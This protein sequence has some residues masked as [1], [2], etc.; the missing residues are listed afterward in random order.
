[1]SY[2]YNYYIG[3]ELNNKIYPLGPFDYKGTI[4]PAV[5]K[6]R[7]FASDLHLYFSDVSDEQISEELRKSFEYEDWNGEKKVSVKYLSLDKFGSYSQ[8]YIK[9]GY[10]L[11]EDV[12]AYLADD[13]S[14]ETFE[15]YLSPE[16][17]SAKLR[18]EVMLGKKEGE[19]SVSDYMFFAYPDLNCKEYEVFMINEM[20]EILNDYRLPEGYK[21][22]ILEDE[23]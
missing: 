12:K 5:S 17:Y 4:Q 11:I 8:N 2:Y 18:N 14:Y 19:H 15:D 10:Y 21:I 16:V 20:I 7:S 13:Y 1:M 9:T 22:V 3:Y 23:G 6:S